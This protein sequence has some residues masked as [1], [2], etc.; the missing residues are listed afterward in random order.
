MLHW[1]LVFIRFSPYLAV[2]CVFRRYIL[3]YRHYF[4]FPSPLSCGSSP[5]F[6]PFQRLGY[7]QLRPSVEIMYNLSHGTTAPSGPEPSHYR[8][9][10]DHTQAH[11][12]WWVSSGRV[13]SPTHRRLPHN[14][15]CSE[16][17]D[18]HDRSG[19]RT[20]NPSKRTAADPRLRPRGNWDRQIEP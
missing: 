11:H 1:L 15:Q 4:H 6:S 2:Y 5:S 18:I 8:G 20:R 9:R 3:L 17:T 16:E 10:R 12:N 14:K 7:Y 19:I 13:I